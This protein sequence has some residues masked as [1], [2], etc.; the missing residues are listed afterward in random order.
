MEKKFRS[1]QKGDSTGQ[2]TQDGESSC[3]GENIGAERLVLAAS[4]G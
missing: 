1:T 3:R 2:R 4:Q